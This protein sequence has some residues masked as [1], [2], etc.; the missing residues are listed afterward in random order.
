MEL[1]WEAAWNEN[2]GLLSTFSTFPIVLI[3]Y[4]GYSF[5]KFYFAGCFVFLL[6]IRTEINFQVSQSI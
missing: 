2:G 5:P 6:Q 1:I 3:Q 4:A